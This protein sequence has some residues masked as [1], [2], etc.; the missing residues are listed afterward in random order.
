MGAG[1]R[2]RVRPRLPL[3]DLRRPR[4]AG[5]AREHGLLLRPGLGGRADARRGRDAGAPRRRSHPHRRDRLEHASYGVVRRARVRA[6]LRRRRRRSRRAR[7]L[8]AVDRHAAGRGA[9][10]AAGRRPRRLRPRDPPRGPL[11]SGDEAV[12]RAARSLVRADGRSP[13]RPLPA[14][15]AS[16]GCGA[17]LERIATPL[18]VCER[19]HER[20]WP[21]QA[22]RLAERLGSRAELVPMPARTPHDRAVLD[23]LA[24]RLR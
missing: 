16:S 7:R 12:A 18:L 13:Y 21:G 22:R 4:P 20:S 11:R 10:G 2:G 8:D 9:R 24:A 1:R 15:G 23:W 17:E 3:D 19:A 6:P 5:G 14:G